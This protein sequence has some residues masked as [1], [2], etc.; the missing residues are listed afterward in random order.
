LLSANSG[1]F[2]EFAPPVLRKLLLF[3]R[4][5]AQKRNFALNVS[6]IRVL[7]S[8]SFIEQARCG[9]KSKRHMS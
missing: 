1:N 6:A 8:H 5:S 9:V 7:S 4:K 2:P 3:S